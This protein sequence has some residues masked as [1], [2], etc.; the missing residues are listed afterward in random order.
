MAPQYTPTV[1]RAW[2]IVD[3]RVLWIGPGITPCYYCGRPA[4]D[5]EHVVSQALASMLDRD[6]MPDL[7]VD[8]VPACHQCNGMLGARFY[9]TLAKRK[10]AGKEYLRRKYQRLVE[11]PQ[12]TDQ[13]IAD[14]ADG[15]LRQYVLESIVAQEE[16]RKMLAW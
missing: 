9:E 15:R 16:V 14:L 3:R 10:E 11:M 1:G 2:K 8:I 13:E 6:D 12:W 4:T 5:A 7:G